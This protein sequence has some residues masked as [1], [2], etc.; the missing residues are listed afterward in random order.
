MLRVLSFG[1][2]WDNHFFLSFLSCFIFFSF[3][4]WRKE[5]RAIR[6]NFWFS[7]FSFSSLENLES[8]N[9]FLPAPS[10]IKSVF[11]KLGILDHGW[12]T[13]RTTWAGECL[14]TYGCQGPILWESD[15]VGLVWSLTMGICFFLTSL[16]EYNCFTLR[17]QLLLYNKV[18]QLYVYIYPHIPSLL[19]L[20]PTFPIP[21][22]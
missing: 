19:R 7:L 8:W 13:F 21:P 10:K 6:W 18:S 16:L 14:K 1:N 20:P 5:I 3:F 4:F 15:L 22:L 11:P 9:S 2:S 17:C 12:C